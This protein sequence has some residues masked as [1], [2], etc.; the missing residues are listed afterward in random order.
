MVVNKKVRMK[1]VGMDGNAF[2]I[3]GRFSA[4]ARKEKWTE[5]EIKKVREEAMRG[6]YDH[7]L[8]TIVDH[9]EDPDE[10]EDE[11]D[12]MED[13]EESD[14]EERDYYIGDDDEEA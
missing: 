9:C 10:T 13:E 2:S 5:E 8:G 11:E 4:Q 6:D 12:E 3:L 14:E 7:L 1:L